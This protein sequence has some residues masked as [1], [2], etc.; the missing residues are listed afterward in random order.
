M[1]KEEAK[2]LGL[3]RYE[4]QDNRPGP[5]F[6]KV[7]ANNVGLG[8]SQWDMNLT[9]GEIIGQHEDGKPIIEQKVK[10]NMSKEFMKA[11][12]NLLSANLAAY[13]KKF[14]VIKLI[15]ASSIPNEP[16]ESEVPPKKRTRK[17][18]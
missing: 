7:Y 15:D 4:D 8:A 3:K 14:G 1:N 2:K 11:L 10:V 17:A 6:M 12:T 18:H 5:N 9:F 16:L 13:E